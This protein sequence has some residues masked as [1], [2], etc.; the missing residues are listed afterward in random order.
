MLSI[1]QALFLSRIRPN[2][3]KP[4]RFDMERT[5]K[6]LHEQLDNMNVAIQ[7]PEYDPCYIPLLAGRKTQLVMCCAFGAVQES[8]P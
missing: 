5:R 1:E 7:I 3:G 8:K 2:D 6:Q 4:R